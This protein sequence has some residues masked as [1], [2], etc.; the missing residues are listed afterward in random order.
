MT[1]QAY[2]HIQCKKTSMIDLLLD[3]GVYKKG[4]KQLYELTLQELE[5]EYA[6]VAQQ[7]ISQ[8]NFDTLLEFVII[9][10]RIGVDLYRKAPDRLAAH[11]YGYPRFYIC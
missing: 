3:A 1:K 5:T 2:S 7:R 4:N 8:W 11:P 6:A 9:E 10:E